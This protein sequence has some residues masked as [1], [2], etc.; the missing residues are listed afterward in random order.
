MSGFSMNLQDMAAKSKTEARE[1][2]VTA[3]ED[4]LTILGG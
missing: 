3:K 2:K 1:A 4:T